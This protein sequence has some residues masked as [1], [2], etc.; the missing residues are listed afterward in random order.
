MMCGGRGK[1]LASD[2]TGCMTRVKGRN[3]TVI[4]DGKVVRIERTG[5]SA[6]M[7][8]GG[9]SKVWPLSRISSVQLVKP[10]FSAQ[11]YFQIASS[12]DAPSKGR[13]ANAKIAKDENS[14]IVTSQTYKQFE[15]LR[16]EI[17]AAM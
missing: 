12:G 13:R 5:L 6:R 14:V 16:D 4:F 11:G 8:Q 7:T 10:G 1:L 17:I 15:A 3:G 2:Y 9:G